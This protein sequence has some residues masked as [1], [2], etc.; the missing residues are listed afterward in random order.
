MRQQ[1]AGLRGE[2][3]PA[4]AAAAEL[5]EQIATIRRL[6]ADPASGLGREEGERWIDEAR[7]RGSAGRLSGVLGGLDPI[8]RD[9]REASERR[10][11]DRDS[12]KSLNRDAED[13]LHLLR[14]EI[15]LGGVD[16]TQRRRILAM[17]EQRLELQRQF[18]PEHQQEIEAILATAAAEDALLGQIEEVREA[19]RAVREIGRQIVADL[20]SGF[21]AAAMNARDLDDAIDVIEDSLLRAGQA[22]LE[23]GLLHLMTGGR[24]GIDLGSLLGGL[25]GI[26]GGGAAKVGSGKAGGGAVFPGTL[27][28][29]GERGIELFAPK[30]P[31]VIIPNHA[32]GSGGGNTVQHFHFHQK[33][34]FEGVAV[35]EEQLG[36]GLAVVKHDTIEAV[37]QMQRRAA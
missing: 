22:L 23:S 13:R 1:V 15:D 7:F 6:M 19:Q 29:V 10:D 37:R 34:Q 14:M 4:A 16:E 18:G 26:G 31:G 9:E 5:A 27:Y 11:R 3:D 25:V 21:A 12:I 28:P 24:E 8:E 2:F 17:E 33:I 35:T 32:L 20:A 36:R 30:V